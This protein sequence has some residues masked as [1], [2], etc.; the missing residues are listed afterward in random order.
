[1]T[2]VYLVSEELLLQVLDAVKYRSDFE[3]LQAGNSI[4]TILSKEPNEPVAL[5]MWH[6]NRYVTIGVVELKDEQPR[7]V[8]YRWTRDA[9]PLFRKDT[10]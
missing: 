4:R 8:Q 7:L 5:G 6:Q 3:S 2:K 1:M 9:E 10:P